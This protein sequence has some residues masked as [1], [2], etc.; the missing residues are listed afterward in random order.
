MY[1]F[2][3]QTAKYAAHLRSR[4]YRVQMKKAIA[5]LLMLSVAAPGW[6]TRKPP[7]LLFILTDNH[8]AWTLGCYGNKEI[9]TPRKS[10]PRPTRP[11]VNS[12]PCRKS[13]PRRVTLADSL[14]NG[15]WGTTFTR[16]RDLLIGSRRPAGTPR[17]FTTTT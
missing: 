2:E 15:T 11:F 16:R 3:F 7:N 4:S 17:P 8:G 14:A 6:A 10:V 12:A 13:W 9:R 5:L 1:I